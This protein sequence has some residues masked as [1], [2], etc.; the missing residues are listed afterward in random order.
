[1][2]YYF[3]INP[4]SRSGSGR[5]I[6]ERLL[7]VIEQNLKI[8]DVFFT[9]YHNHA[10]EY[11]SFITNDISSPITI[12]VLGG[13]GTL[14]EVINGIKQAEYVTLG[15]IPTGS[16]NDFARSLG[17]TKNPPKNLEIILKPSA[18][19]IL[20][21]GEAVAPGKDPRRFCVSC[22]IGFDASITHEALSSPWKARLNSIRLGKLTYVFIALKQI[23]KLKKTNA[24]LSV[25]GGKPIPVK[26][27]VFMSTHIHRY[28][29][30]GFAFSPKA[31][32]EDG[33]LDICVISNMSRLKMLCLFPMAFSGK[34]IR[35]K[36]VDIYRCKKAVI[37]AKTPLTVH[38]DGET[39]G[40][41]KQLNLTCKHQAIKIIVG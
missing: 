19:K 39:Y 15:Y 2:M 9:Q 16:S 28:E 18:F 30:G 8:Y 20:D 17:I 32:P 35:F 21:C 34:H 26:K 29:G 12:V 22:G 6:W 1:M 23:I 40:F 4:E 38:T 3:I 41:E 25:D 10:T 31:D 13:D 36:G 11:V 5:K 7:P 24:L 14:N 37:Q 33:L 27:M